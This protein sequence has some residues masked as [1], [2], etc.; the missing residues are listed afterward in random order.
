MAWEKR[1]NYRGDGP[2]EHWLFK[3]CA[4]VCAER[5]RSRK[6]EAKLLQTTAESLA[7]AD[8]G[9][10]AAEHAALL[11][12]HV[13]NTVADAVCD[14]PPRQRQTVELRIID[15]KSTAEVAERMHCAPGTVKANLHKAMKHLA[16]KTRAAVSTLIAARAVL[17]AESPD[18]YL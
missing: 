17:D 8:V 11:M 16:P 14:L 18:G 12:Q 9:S 4:S 10:R 13:V 2:I 15:K 7:V 3:I 5:L 1:D 6:R